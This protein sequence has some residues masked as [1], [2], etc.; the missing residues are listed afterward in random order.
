MSPT[1]FRGQAEAVRLH[2]DSSSKA[3]QMTYPNCYILVK[4]A[5]AAELVTPKKS[6]S[7]YYLAMRARISLRKV[8]FLPTKNN[9]FEE[10]LV[11]KE[12]S[13]CRIGSPTQITQEDVITSLSR[14]EEVRIT[15][16]RASSGCCN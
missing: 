5:L 16:H 12:L 6:T 2:H 8:G 14:G 11:K 10:E 3:E 9:A 7:A 1:V 15:I 13:R 4:Q